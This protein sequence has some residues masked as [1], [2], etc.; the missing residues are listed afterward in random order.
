MASKTRIHKL[1]DCDNS[2]NSAEKLFLENVQKCKMYNPLLFN[3]VLDSDQS[4]FVMHI[5]TRFLQH[6]FENLNDLLLQ[7]NFQPDILCVSETK[8]KISPLINISLP[9]YEFFHVDSPTNAGGV[10]IYV[11]KQLQYD[12]IYD[13]NLDLLSCEDIWI[14]VFKKNSL[15]KYLIG[16]VYRHPNTSKSD[17]ITRFGDILQKINSTNLETF[18]VGDFNIDTLCSNFD[19]LSPSS[20]DYLLSFSC[21][22]FSQLID[23]PIHIPILLPH[24]RLLIT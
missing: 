6:N 3:P 19:E 14:N 18:I 8:I 1:D 4:L 11:S 23:I 16:V 15:K 17:F 21:N 22:G 12:L 24:K 10:A 13:F 7:M 20:K 5:N 9:G 2:I